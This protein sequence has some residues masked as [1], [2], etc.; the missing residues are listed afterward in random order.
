MAGVTTTGGTELKG[1]SN[2]KVGN[3][4]CNTTRDNYKKPDTNCYSSSGK[5]LVPPITTEVQSKPLP[6]APHMRRLLLQLRVGLQPVQL[7]K[8]QES[9]EVLELVV[10]ETFFQTRRP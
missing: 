8:Q 1:Q 4:W 7:G 5:A 2:R 3:V 10:G 9:P 6:K